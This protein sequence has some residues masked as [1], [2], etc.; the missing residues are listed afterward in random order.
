MSLQLLLNSTYMQLGQKNSIEAS[1]SVCEKCESCG[2]SED[3]GKT[4]GEMSESTL[5]ESCSILEAFQP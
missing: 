4:H 2:R 5:I 3:V 1:E